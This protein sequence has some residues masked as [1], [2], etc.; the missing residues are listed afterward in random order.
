MPADGEGRILEAEK[1]T[2]TAHDNFR[3]LYAILAQ[4][5][6]SIPPYLTDV[7]STLEK[8][9]HNLRTI[10]SS[11]EASE[12]NQMAGIMATLKSGVEL[13][14]SLSFVDA[15]VR[16]MRV[17]GARLRYAAANGEE[18]SNGLRLELSSTECTNIKEMAE[19]YDRFLS[20]MITTHNL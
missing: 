19:K 2:R 1:I 10:T 15:L 6:T 4:H 9:C 17:V 14:H 18:G 5:A 12:Q 16:D 8:L 7:G 20:S 3:T 11:I 13:D